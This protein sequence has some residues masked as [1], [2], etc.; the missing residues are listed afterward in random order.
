M[1]TNSKP[2]TPFWDDYDNGAGYEGQNTF[3]STWSAPPPPPP[4]YSNTPPPN[5]VE[6]DVVQPGWAA[7]E[8]F[9]P[10]L[11]R[12][13][14]LKK[15]AFDSSKS[16]A[17]KRWSR[18]WIHEE[19]YFSMNKLSLFAMIIALMFLGAL[20]FTSGFLM[21]VN[22][23]GIGSPAKMDATSISLPDHMPTKGASSQNPVD[24][25]G[26]NV[27]SQ[28]A[29]VSGVAMVPNS[30]LPSSAQHPKGPT[31]GAHPRMP[32][33]AHAQA[34]VM[35]QQPAPVDMAAAQPVYS[36]VQPAPVYAA[37]QPVYGPVYSQQPPQPAY[38]QGAYAPAYGQ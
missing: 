17:L 20:F 5:Y 9:S 30:R 11:Q 8:P 37:P 34:P 25:K 15:N 35:P 26:P 31:H 18:E 24:P 29:N 22:L 23:Y 12:S 14:P 7:N 33:H 19:L 28:Y 13:L 27:P 3:R 10:F 36:Y 4:R 1:F 21:A 16:G 32:T 2:Y 6:F 38:V